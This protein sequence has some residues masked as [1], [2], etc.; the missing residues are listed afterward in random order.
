MKALKKR[1]LKLNKDKFV[2]QILTHPHSTFISVGRY[3][4]DQTSQELY[5]IINIRVS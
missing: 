5:G 2:K 3:C 1:F 4:A